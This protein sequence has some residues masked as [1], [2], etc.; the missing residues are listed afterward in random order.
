LADRA[1]LNRVRACLQARLDPDARSSGA[2]RAVRRLGQLQ[3]IRSVLQ[4]CGGHEELMRSLAALG[5]AWPPADMGRG[6]CLHLVVSRLVMQ[7]RQCLE[8]D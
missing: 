4:H 5:V 3:R 6:V 2:E 8:A 1:D 7:R